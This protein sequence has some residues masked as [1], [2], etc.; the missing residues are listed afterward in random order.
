MVRLADR[1][2]MTIA[3]DWDVKQQNNNSKGMRDTA[4][5]EEIF[6][7]NTRLL[8]WKNNAKYPCNHST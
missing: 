7:L 1:L 3:V 5:G 2:N 8:V 6:A 4:L